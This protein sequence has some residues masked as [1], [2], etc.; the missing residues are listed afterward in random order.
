MNIGF[1]L[2][3]SR[4]MGNVHHSIMDE[5][6]F[7][8][9]LY[10]GV[11][12]REGIGEFVPVSVVSFS[13]TSTLEWRFEDCSTKLEA[14][15][16]FENL[17]IYADGENLHFDVCQHWFEVRLSTVRLLFLANKGLQMKLG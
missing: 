10:D 16:K 5:I 6:N 12:K 14:D 15:E 4:S 17:W 1:A 9:D 8:R 2:D 13:G 11:S 7:A 3:K